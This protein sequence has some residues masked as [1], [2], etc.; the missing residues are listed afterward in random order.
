MIFGSL[1]AGT[2]AASSAKFFRAPSSTQH[3][4]AACRFFRRTDSLFRV[5]TSEPDP[6]TVPALDVLCATSRA[7]VAV[8]SEAASKALA[9]QVVRRYGN[10]S[11]ALRLEYLRFLAAEF[12]PDPSALKAAAEVWLSEPTDESLWALTRAVQSP[13]QALFPAINSARRGIQTVLD[14]RRD[15]LDW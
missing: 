2:T 11:G 14:L 3:L 10:L 12:G 15:T 13:R 8:S 5:P 9:E 1:S 4:L 7:L 6:E